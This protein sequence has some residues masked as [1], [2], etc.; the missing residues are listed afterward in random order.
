MTT[1]IVFLAFFVDMNGQLLYLKVEAQVNV[2]ISEQASFILT[3]T[4]M[5]RIYNCFLQHQPN[6]VCFFMCMQFKIE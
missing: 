2:L 5:L 1:L 3:R 4:G 6:Q